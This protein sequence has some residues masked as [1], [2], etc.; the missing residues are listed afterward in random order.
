[1]THTVD[2]Q[3]TV[4]KNEARTLCLITLANVFSFNNSFTVVFPDDLQ[5]RKVALDLPPHLNVSTHYLEKLECSTALLF[6][7]ISQNNVHFRLLRTGSN[8][9]STDLSLAY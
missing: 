3:Y 4:T 8:F 5:R 9:C 6:M 7:H 1:L 2:I